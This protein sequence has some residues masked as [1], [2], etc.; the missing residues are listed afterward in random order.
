MYLKHENM[1]MVIFLTKQRAVNKN[2]A[3]LFSD[4]TC[5]KFTILYSISLSFELT[6]PARISFFYF[7]SFI[8]FDFW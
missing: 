3:Q 6:R 2:T 5:L 8:N 7:F 1:E 4:N